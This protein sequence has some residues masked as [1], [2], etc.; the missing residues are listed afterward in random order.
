MLLVRGTLSEDQKYYSMARAATSLV[1]LVL[2]LGDLPLLH[3]S[4]GRYAEHYYG[5]TQLTQLATPTR[6]TASFAATHSST[7]VEA[8]LAS[9][10]PLELQQPDG[11]WIKLQPRGDERIHYMVDANGYLVVEE[12]IPTAVSSAGVFKLYVVM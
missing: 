3:H 5:S 11:T 6:T 7:L 1:F 9:P 2:A 4:S 10:H 12:E 8:V